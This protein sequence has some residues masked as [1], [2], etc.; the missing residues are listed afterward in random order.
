MLN[1]VFRP[2]RIMKDDDMTSKL[3]GATRIILET[4]AR[5]GEG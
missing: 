5:G 2:A 3:H 4:L 1:Q